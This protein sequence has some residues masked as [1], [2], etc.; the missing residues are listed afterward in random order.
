VP[1]AAFADA[2][3]GPSAF[4]DGQE[5]PGNDNAVF[6][7]GDDDG[8][9]TVTIDCLFGDEITFKRKTGFP[10]FHFALGTARRVE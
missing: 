9:G 4:S 7:V 2:P 10:A 8:D 3:R 6:I 1:G 5:F